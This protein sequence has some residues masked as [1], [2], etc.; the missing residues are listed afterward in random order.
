MYNPTIMTTPNIGASLFKRALSSKPKDP[1]EMLSFERQSQVSEPEPEPEQDNGILGIL[2]SI[3]NRKNP[4]ASEYEKY[5]Q[6]GIP[7]NT[8]RSG[9]AKAAAIGL[10]GLGSALGDEQ[11]PQRIIQA[12]NAPYERD[13]Q[14]YETRGKSLAARMNIE[15]SRQKQD[16]DVINAMSEY[17][18]ELNKRKLD[19]KKFGLDLDKFGVE[20]T[21]SESRNRNRGLTSGVNDVTGRP[22]TFNKETGKFD[23]FGQTVKTPYQQALTDTRTTQQIS[24]DNIAKRQRELENIRFGHDLT[25]R[26]TPTAAQTAKTKNGNDPK[27]EEFLK[28]EADEALKLI[29]ELY[30]SD[31]DDLSSLSKSAVGKSSLFNFIPTTEGYTGSSKINS[32]KNKLTLSI[33]QGMKAASKTGATGFGQMNLRELGVL[34]KAASILDTKLSED[35]FKKELKKI[36]ERLELITKEPGTDTNADKRALELIAKYS[37]PGGGK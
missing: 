15:N 24:S 8:G 29:K 36:K 4:V 16:L 19:E 37:K 21:E 9:W 6:E 25:L 31:K 26:Q 3:R 18:K 5:L 10:S 35:D 1:W 14:N 32:L 12:Y 2:E 28:S 22:Y 11:A 17:E 33:I 27:D 30:D 23:E 7:E 20:R 13:L 34:E